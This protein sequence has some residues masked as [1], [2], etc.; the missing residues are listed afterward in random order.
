MT[1]QL[2]SSRV[3]VIQGRVR[4]VTMS[5]MTQPQKPRALIS[6]ISYWLQ[7][8]ALLAGGGDCPR[9]WI[10]K[11]ENHW[12][13]SKPDYHFQVPIE[14]DHA[15]SPRTI[16]F[17]SFYRSIKLANFSYMNYSD[18]PT[19]HLSINFMIF[20]V[21]LLHH[22]ADEKMKAQKSDFSNVPKLESSGRLGIKLLC[23][24]PQSSALAI[25]PHSCHQASKIPHAF[26]SSRINEN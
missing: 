15:T 11:H 20:W 16:V 13:P 25:T 19:W 14:T 6:V 24:G 10:S 3:C 9:A 17:S 18:D 26:L 4:G 1:W 12:G 7:R 2:A 8:S 21:L 5:F 23:Y 22:A